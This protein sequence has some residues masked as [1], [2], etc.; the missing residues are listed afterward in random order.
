MKVNMNQFWRDGFA[1]VPKVFSPVFIDEL[2]DD[3]YRTMNE[4]VAGGRTVVPS[5]V[6]P[7]A[8]RRKTL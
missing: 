4:E 7:R 6:A 3:V 5:Q 2:R 1:H 8:I